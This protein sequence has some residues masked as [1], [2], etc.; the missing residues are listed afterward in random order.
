MD[1]RTKLI[2]LTF[3]WQRSLDDSDMSI[4]LGVLETAH[5]IFYEW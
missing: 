1:E 4:N 2:S 5:P 3:Y